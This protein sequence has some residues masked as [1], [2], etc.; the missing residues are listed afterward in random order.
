MATKQ[1]LIDKAQEIK[2][3]ITDTDFKDE[4]LDSLLKM[5]TQLCDVLWTDVW[6]K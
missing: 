6:K 5:L 1:N 4:V 2:Q 3:C